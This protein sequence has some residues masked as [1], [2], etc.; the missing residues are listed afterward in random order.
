MKHTR[1]WKSLFELEYSTFSYF[2]KPEPE[3]TDRSPKPKVEKNPKIETWSN[4]ILNSRK[5]CQKVMHFG[6]ILVKIIL[7]NP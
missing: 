6:Q 3:K 5:F 1:A 2:L 4:Q 7:T